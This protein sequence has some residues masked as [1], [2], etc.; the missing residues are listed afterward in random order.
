MGTV[1]VTGCAGLIGSNFAQWLL[2]HT[3]ERV[4][5]IDDLSCGLPQN[6]PGALHA[7]HRATIGEDTI[8]EIFEAERPRVV[9]HFAA[10]AAE[11]LS[12]FIRTY[13]YRNNLVATAEVVNACIN[14]GVKRLVFTSSMATYGRGKAPFDEADPLHPI[15]PYGVAKAAA[16]RDI[17]IAGEQHGL[18][19]VIIRPHNVYGPGQAYCQQYRN[20]LAIWMERYRRGLPM[21]VYGDGSQTRAFSYIGDTMPCFYRA[22][23]YAKPLRQIINLGGIEPVTILDAARALQGVL[24]GSEIVHCEPRHE[25]HTAWSTWQKSVDLLG[26]EFKT[27]LE[28][29]LRHM[30]AWMEKQPTGCDLPAM[31]LE[32]SRGLY[33]FWQ[34]SSQMICDPAASTAAD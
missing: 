8:D 21:R 9:Y 30:W 26:Y 16:E 20:V 4:V 12:P 28:E 34:P 18:D 31:P 15:D 1:I 3:T 29:G 33:S 27:P 5:G 19:W 32:V 25:V 2:D 6:V 13:N 22:G 17:Q 24:E 10:Y 11:G 23:F 14:H 7:F